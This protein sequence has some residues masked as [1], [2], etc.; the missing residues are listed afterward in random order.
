[1]F[2][3]RECGSIDHRIALLFDR[4]IDSS[5]AEMPVKLHKNIVASGLGEILQ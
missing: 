3:S 5:A 2:L 4:H 1:M